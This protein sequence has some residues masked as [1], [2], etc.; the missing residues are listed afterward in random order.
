MVGA[1][2]W[3]VGWAMGLDYSPC[4]PNLLAKSGKI[5]KLPRDGL[6]RRHIHTIFGVASISRLFI[7]S[8]RRAKF[9]GHH[10]WVCRTN[11]EETII[12]AYKNLE[13]AIQASGNI[14]KMMRNS[15]I[16]AYVYPVVAPEFTNWRD[17]QRA[18]RETCVL[19][20]Q[21]PP[22]GQSVRRRS[23][24]DE[25]AV[26]SRHQHVQEFRG[27]QGQAVCAVQLRRP[28]H[29]RRH[30]VLSGRE[31]FRLR[32]PQ[33]D[34]EL[35]RIPRQDRQIRRQDRIR[36]PLALAP[37][38]QAGVRANSTAIRSRARTPRR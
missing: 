2:R 15:Q 32:R 7:S 11:K 18:W 17:E 12:M 13:E 3:L 33:P 8:R 23:G 10:V 9:R 14:V 30:S 5:W 16:G 34:G 6:C 20:D 21:S 19:F 25:A 38:G 37:D 24:R 1:K 31:R 26:A 36:R 28:C 35:D 29:R 27:Q 4:L 22:H